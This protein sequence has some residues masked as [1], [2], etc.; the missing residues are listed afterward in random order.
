MKP[1]YDSR[2][3]SSLWQSF[4][5]VTLDGRCGQMI[6]TV[7]LTDDRARSRYRH[8]A[9]HRTGPRG[10]HHR[11]VHRRRHLDRVRHSGFPLAGRAVDQE[12]TDTVRRIP[13][14]PG[15][16]QRILA[17]ALRHGRTFQRRA[18]GTR[19]PGAGE[20]LSRRQGA[21]RGHP[22]HRQSAPGL[23]DQAARRHRAARQYDLRP[24]SRLQGALRARL[25]AADE[26]TPAMAARPIARTAAALSRPRPSRSARRCPMPRCS[27]RGPVAG[28]RSVSGDRLVA[29]LFGR[30]R[31]FL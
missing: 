31:A 3:G 30:R 2:I 9:P 27:A 12:Q 5:P 14:Q 29:C 21:G 7:S 20:P 18:A 28:L 1:D 22:E 17:A 10:R 6:W 16:A 23:G 25:G 11:A 15:G 8:R 26:W 24:L 13:G 19:S 4:G